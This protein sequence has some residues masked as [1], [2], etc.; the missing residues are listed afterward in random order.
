MPR[1]SK[2]SAPRTSL[3]KLVSRETAKRERE[4]ERWRERERGL[5]LKRPI[6]AKTIIYG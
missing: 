5:L 4:K 3:E 6:L 2:M 1:V